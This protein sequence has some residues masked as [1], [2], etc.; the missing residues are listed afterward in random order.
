MYDKFDCTSRELCCL[1]G[2][3][4]GSDDCGC[5]SCRSV[6]NEVANIENKEMLSLAI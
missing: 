1:I 6:I 2:D 3:S 4:R 5:V